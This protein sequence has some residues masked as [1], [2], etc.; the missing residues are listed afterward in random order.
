MPFETYENSPE[1]GAPVE[2]YTFRFGAERFDFTS[3]DVPQSYLAVEYECA[4]I[5]RS[6]LEETSELARSDLTL[7]VAHE[8]SIAELFSPYP[9]SEVVWV[10]IRRMH[11]NDVSAD[12]KLMW[13]GRVIA[14]SWG[15]ATA[16]LTCETVLT[17][18]RRPGLARGYQRACPYVLY[19]PGCNVA[20][21][22]F[23][24][25]ATISAVDRSTITSADFDALPD[26]Y[27]AGGYIEWIA[28]TRT[29]RRAIRSHVGTDITVSHPIPGLT[30]GATVN[31]AA[32]CDHSPTVCVSRFANGANFGGFLHIPRKNPF[33]TAP[34][35]Y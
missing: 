29:S 28:G 30:F 34:I 8:F 27:L 20:A 10:E 26:G 3:A 2:L 5:E 19:R 7:K 14:C 1:S 33:G 4:P 25:P 23:T 17:S 22:L 32:G 6:E 31:V 35:F 9:P 24:T 16:E 11:R 18:M 15:N 21:A 12:A 13:L